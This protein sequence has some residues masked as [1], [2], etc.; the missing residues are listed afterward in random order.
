VGL[1]A[2][3]FKAVSDWVLD[4]F[5]GMCSGEVEAWLGSGKLKGQ[6]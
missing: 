5:L 3:L 6:W 2:A 1:E 4:G